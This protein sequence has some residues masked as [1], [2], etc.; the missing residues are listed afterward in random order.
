MTHHRI[1]VVAGQSNATGVFGAPRQLEE[2]PCD[3]EIGLFWRH[4]SES[5][6]VVGLQ[7]QPVR[8]DSD[9]P[10]SP[11]GFGPEMTLARTLHRHRP[12]GERVLVVKRSD[13]GTSL[14]EH[15]RPPSMPGYRS[16][17]D[18]VREARDAVA[19]AGDT[20]E[21]DS[22]VWVQ[23]ESDVA[24]FAD[25][26]REGLT[27]LIASLRDDL[28]APGL[29][30]VISRINMPLADGERRTRVRSAQVE[31][32]EADPLADWIDTDDLDLD[33][34]GLHL[35]SAGLEAVGARAAQRIIAMR[36]SGDRGER[37]DA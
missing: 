21:V 18:T 37:C 22:F 16:L 13:D 32:A 3:P 9:G 24:R 5:A 25:Q 2:D 1:T 31:V 17:V 33:E 6:G 20:S 36:A 7:V 4:F 27:S 30:V 34:V 28:V 12:D 11:L 8:P 35:R 14:F 26:Y 19:D 23:G 15:W 29:L 10:L